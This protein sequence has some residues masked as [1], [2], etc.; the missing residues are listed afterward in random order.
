MHTHQTAIVNVSS[1]F[2]N[3]LG[4]MIEGLWHGLLI[5]KTAQNS[6]LSAKLRYDIGEEDIRPID[7]YNPGQISLE[8][9]L[10]DFRTYGRGRI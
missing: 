7:S 9:T 6:E 8:A 5:G 1:R 3:A 10:S 4:A 2:F